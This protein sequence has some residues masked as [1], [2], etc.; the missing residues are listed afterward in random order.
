MDPASRNRVLMIGGALIVIA[1]LLVCGPLE[2][3]FGGQPGL[4]AVETTPDVAAAPPASEAPAIDPTLAGELESTDA[5]TGVAIEE[6][7]L[8]KPIEAQPVEALPIV[9]VPPVVAA[10]P[11]RPPVKVAKEAAPTVTRAEAPPVSA[12]GPE[13]PVALVAAL[14]TAEERAATAADDFDSSL[15]D[16]TNA[17][18]RD[19]IKV[20]D[21]F[22]PPVD[23]GPRAAMS[24]QGF[25]AFA[26]RPCANPGAGCQN[27]QPRQRARPTP[28]AGGSVIPSP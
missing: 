25:N 2:G 28:A 7:D 3:R 1:L 16:I 6:S 22:A 15:A 12:A 23:S 8:A 27:V 10:A 18:D 9:P 20:V 11:D 26:L 21:R 19:G 17:L 5:L 13:V 4:D 24:P 14:P